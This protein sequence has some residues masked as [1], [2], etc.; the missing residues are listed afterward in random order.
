MSS[1]VVENVGRILEIGKELQDDIMPSPS[2]PSVPPQ[3]F[4]AT[5]LAKSTPTSIPSAPLVIRQESF[6]QDLV[7]PVDELVTDST[8]PFQAIILAQKSG[9]H[10][11]VVR[12]SMVEGYETILFE[13]NERIEGDFSAGNLWDALPPNI[14]LAPNKNQI[15]YI[16]EDGLKL[17]SLVTVQH[18]PLITIIQPQP[19]NSDGSPLWSVEALHGTYFLVRPRWSADSRYISFSQAHYEGASYG[20]YDT[21]SGTYDWIRGKDDEHIGHIS[22]TWSPVGLSVLE[23]SSEGYRHPGLFVST[24]NVWEVKN[25]AKKFGKRDAQF[26]AA[27][28][29]PDGTKIAFTYRDVYEDKENI[30]AFVDSSG[31]NFSIVDDKGW[32]ETPFFAPDGSHIYYVVTKEGRATLVAYEIESKSSSEVLR[33]PTEYDVWEEPQW[34][35]SYLVLQG[36][37]HGVDTTLR[38]DVKRLIILDLENRIMVYASPAYDYYTTFAGFIN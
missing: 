22:L 23:P 1:P 3:H 32:K 33:F 10:T 15:A 34:I 11:V 4:S 27:N 29:S 38:D 37:A 2:L 16:D 36:N 28:F 25:L 24:D 19:E 35:G 5:P 9:Y 17:F 7:I 8:S 31:R 12:R 30:L 6:S 26:S 13:Y 18:I 21:V 14:A 20:M